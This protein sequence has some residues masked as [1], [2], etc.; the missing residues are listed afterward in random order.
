MKVAALYD[1]HGNVR[2]LEAVL[3]DGAA[4]ADVVVFGGDLVAGPWP[5]ETLDLAQSLGDRARY[6]SGNWERYVRERR[7]DRAVAWL[8][9]Q[10][11][12]ADLDWPAT[13]AVDGVLYCHAT[14]RSDQE[15]V[16]PEWPESDWDAFAGPLVVCGHMH[17]QYDVVRNGTRVV[18]PGSV[19]VPV[20]RAT[21]WWATITDGTEVELRTTDYDVTAAAA[22]MRTSPLPRAQVVDALVEPYSVEQLLALLDGMRVGVYGGR[23]DPPHNGHVALAAG[24]KKAFG[25]ERLHVYVAARPG[26]KSASTPIDVRL[27]LARAAFPDDEVLVDPHPRTIDLLR[28]ERFAHP[29]FVMGADELC[30]FPSWKEPDTLLELTELAVGTRPG[31]PRDRLEGVL[32]QL[33]RPER[34]HLFDI[35][36]VA[37][38]STEIR[39]GAPLDGL[40]PP[41]VAGLIRL[42]GL[43]TGDA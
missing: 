40:V 22:E 17:V 14:P 41:A 1:V 27:E 15:L 35:D 23:F 11:R 19:G 26:H 42:H 4:E 21:A 2:A 33:A 8:A 38:S 18:N 7:R 25:I 5:R 3:A 37:A 10:L 28:A 24:A 9:E 13:L 12:C 29:L 43:Y 16:L 34:V 36:P 20:V 39:A 6:I 32:A 30:D 31:F